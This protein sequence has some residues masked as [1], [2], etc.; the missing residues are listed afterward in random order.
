[1]QGGNCGSGA[2]S[3]GFAEFAGPKLLTGNIVAD[4]AVHATLGGVGALAAGGKFAN[5][6][7]TGAFGYLF[8]CVMH[9]NTCTKGDEQSIKAAMVT[10]KT[11]TCIRQ[12]AQYAR[13]AGMAGVSQFDMGT[14]LVDFFGFTTWA[15]MQFSPHGRTVSE[16]IDISKLSYEFFEGK[17]IDSASTAAGLAYT[18]AMDRWLHGSGELAGRFSAF[19]GMFVE[20]VTHWYYQSVV[21]SPASHTI[22]G[23]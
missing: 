3:A 23:K 7:L 20:K 12:V 14:V 19:S 1:M 10:C 18:K 8:N 22:A 9:P 16:A 13:E 4:T 6:A 2:V 21:P 5:G 15:P 17:Y 11:Q